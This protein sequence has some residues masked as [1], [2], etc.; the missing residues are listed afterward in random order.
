MTM[1]N[2]KL[3]LAWSQSVRRTKHRLG[4]SRLRLARLRTR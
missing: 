1:Q 3:I 2:G 4:F